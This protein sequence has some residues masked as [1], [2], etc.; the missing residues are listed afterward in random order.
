MCTST[1][2]S[3]SW[4]YQE[5]HF[6]LSRFSN[7]VA[8]VC[9][10]PHKKIRPARVGVSLKITSTAELKKKTSRMAAKAGGTIPPTEQDLITK[11]SRKVA[12]AQ[13]L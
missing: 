11:R 5:G 4:C 10:Q 6:S 2:T 1:P 8:Q 7:L 9:G 3:V 12:A 13:A